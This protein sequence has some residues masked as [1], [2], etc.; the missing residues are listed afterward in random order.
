MRKRT[1]TKMIIV[2]LVIAGSAAL[3]FFGARGKGVYSLSV[4]ELSTSQKAVS[5]GGV[6][7]GGRVI[8]GSVAYDSA[9]PSL[10][11]DITDP[12]D[13][14]RVTIAYKNI[15]PDGFKPGSDVIVEGQYRVAEN[16]LEAT[17][18]MTKCPSKYEEKKKG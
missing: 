16:R 1:R 13:G 14:G 2:S 6:R 4:P 7:V 11:F 18:L 8:E 15:M 3:L 9:R 10:V 5:G 12:K 17:V